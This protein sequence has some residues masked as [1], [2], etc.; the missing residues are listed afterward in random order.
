MLMA[1]PALRLQGLY[2]ALASMA[3]ARMAEFV[4]FDQPEVFGNGAR[5]IAPFHLLGFDTSQP[6]SILGVHFG[7]DVGMLF[8][9]T[10]LFGAIGMGLVLLRRAPFGRRLVAMR[11][12]PA[13]CA[14]M[15]MNLTRT[16]LTVFALSAAIAGFGGALLGVLL[17][18]A[19]TPDFQMLKGLPYL[20][21]IVFGGVGVVTGALLGGFLLAGLQTWLLLLF[22]DVV[23]NLF[24]TI[25]FNLFQVFQ[26]IGAGTLGI[27]IGRQPAGVIPTVGHD[28]R[29]NR[30]RKQ[31]Q[32]GEPP[33]P[34]AS[35]PEV[36]GATAG[37]RPL[38][39]DRAT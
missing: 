4:L 7:A 21:L 32:A 2:L 29:A 16:K 26:R 8:L 11:D 18:S 15:G 10:A 5:R 6:F 27:A 9:S 24:N 19:S 13:G 17:G 38:S 1:L 35:R 36:P 14:T 22:P 31:A 28:F 34:T 30:E 37:P 25:R 39:P 3:F 20:L 12:S 33:G 23:I